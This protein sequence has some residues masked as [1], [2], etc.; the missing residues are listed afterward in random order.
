LNWCTR[1]C[2]PLRNHSA[3]WPHRGGINIDD[4]P[5][6]QPPIAAAPQSI[7]LRSRPSRPNR[8]GKG[9]GLQIGAVRGWLLAELGYPRTCRVWFGLLRNIGLAWMSVRRLWLNA[10]A[11][12][13]VRECLDSNG[14]FDRVLPYQLNGI[15][16]RRRLRLSLISSP[17]RC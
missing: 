8:S 9:P 4:Q 16:N 2:R 1:F 12:R 13:H 6:K 15:A 5:L 14:N 10:C 3:T 7:L 17:V 11:A